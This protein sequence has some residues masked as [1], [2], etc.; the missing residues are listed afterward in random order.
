MIRLFA[1]TIL[2]VLGTIGC[3]RWGDTTPTPEAAT[4]EP[5]SRESEEDEEP[6]LEMMLWETKGVR[7][8]EA[9][10]V[11]ATIECH[12]MAD[13][14]P[15]RRGTESEECPREIPAD[16]QESLRPCS[17]VPIRGKIARED[18]GVFRIRFPRECPQ[19]P[20]SAR[21]VL[22]GNPLRADFAN[23]LCL[24]SLVV[25]SH[26]MMDCGVP[27]EWGAETVRRLA[28]DQ[29][30]CEDDEIEVRVHRNENDLPVPTL[31]WAETC[32]GLRLYRCN[33]LDASC[34]MVEEGSD[35]YVALGS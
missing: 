9:V 22:K 2:T 35:Q 24:D 31:Y 12:P 10:S 20:V 23:I 18:H 28:A 3:Y 17:A 34:H 29:T 14:T 5:V 8:C 33:G 27:V 1:L 4:E 32:A 16:Q 30:Q 21:F 15:R 26:A 19:G 6:L 25:P 11:E 7:L 13:R